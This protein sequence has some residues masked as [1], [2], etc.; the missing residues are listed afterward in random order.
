MDSVK[1]LDSL[2]DYKKEFGETSQRKLASIYKTSH[3]S[4]GRR[5]RGD[6]VKV[7]HKQG[8]IF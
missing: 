7:I 5:I 2:Y 4:I 8:C 6:K 3:L 1:S